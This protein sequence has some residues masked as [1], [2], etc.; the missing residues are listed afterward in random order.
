MRSGGSWIAG[1][2]KMRAFDRTG[3]TLAGWNLLV[4]AIVIAA[5]MLIAVVVQVRADNADIDDQLRA[6]AQREQSAMLAVHGDDEHEHDLGTEAYSADTPGIFAFWID[7]RGTVVRNTRGVTLTGLPDQQ[8]IS[9]ALSGREQFTERTPDGVPVRL[10]TVPVVAEGRVAGAVQ[11]GTSLLASRQSVAQTMVIFLLTGILGIVL[12]GFGSVFLALRAMRPIR[13]AFERQRRFIADASHELRTPVAV[14]RARAESLARNA[15][16]RPPEEQRELLR[17]QRDADELSVLLSDLLDLE[18]LDAGEHALS[19]EPVALVD[20]VEEVAAQFKPLADEE[21]VELR[22]HSGPVWAQ[23]HLARL[24]QV[25]RALVDNALKHTTA[26]GRVDIEAD[27]RG[28]WA[29]V[30]VVDTGEGIP[31]QELSKVT[32]PFYRVPTGSPADTASTPRGGAGLGLSIS[33]ELVRLMR[34]DLRI[35]SRPGQGTTVTIRLPLA[36]TA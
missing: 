22:A 14:V 12:A 32:T 17:L 3:W 34:G 36:G 19:L 11:V 9:V 27:V 28:H 30:R 25:L 29:V 20:V 23:A 31:E 15:T 16:T 13:F 33:S 24:R 4:L 1:Q 2:T 26:G 35:D 18:R 5:T 21:H 6:S 10:L 8:A 7:R